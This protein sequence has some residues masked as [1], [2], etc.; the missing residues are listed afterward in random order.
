MKKT[1]TLLLLV[2]LFI[3]PFSCTKR[4]ENY[5]PKPRGY[6]RI[7][8]PPHHYQMLDTILPFRFAYSKEAVHAFEPK[9]EGKY[10]IN[11]DYP[12]LKATLNMTYFPLYNNNLRE[13]ALDEQKMVNF[14]IE[15]GKADDVQL[16]YIN[17]P[18][19][20]V[21]GTWYDLYGKWVA[22]PLQFWVSDSSSHYL[23]ASLYF[24]FAPDNDSL[25]PV[26]QYLREDVLELINTFSWK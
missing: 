17:D 5:T 3:L 13:L 14:H 18:A 9:E 4:D 21:Y 20:K 12:S 26:I 24:N 11:V 6:M 2:L 16:N 22:T 7:D 19:H 15:H 8:L 10:W 23:R 25:Q 1:G